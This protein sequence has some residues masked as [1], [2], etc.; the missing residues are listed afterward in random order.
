MSDQPKRATWR[1]W[2]PADAPEPFDLITRGEL[3]A[4]LAAHG[5]PLTERQLRY[6]ERAD[7]P[8][9]GPV[10]QFYRDAIHATYPRWYPEIVQAAAGLLARDTPPGAIRL[11]LQTQFQLRARLADAPDSDTL[12]ELT[13]PVRQ[14]LVTF[15]REHDISHAQLMLVRRDGRGKGYVFTLGD[16][17]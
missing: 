8:L 2:W 11:H 10:R 17:E 16:G 13:E 6:W 9:P 4:Q 5:P 3:L 7:G 15:M 12:P 14:A 1:D